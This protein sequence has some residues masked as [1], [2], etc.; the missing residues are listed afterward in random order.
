LSTT[1]AAEQLYDAL[2]TWNKRGSITITA[3]SLDF[4]KQVSPNRFL[5]SLLAL[6]G[7]QIQLYSSA[8]V[9]TY[10][11]STAQYIAITS[12]VKTYADGFVAIVQ[13]YQGSGG[14]LAEQFSRSNGS[15]L[16]AADLT[17]S[18]AASLTAFDARAS[19]V[20]ASWGASGLTVPA[21]CSS[22]GGGGGGTVAVS[23]TVTATTVFGGTCFVMNDNLAR[24]AKS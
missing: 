24:L 18:Y 11:S 1:A 9:G 17:W 10:A 2:Y 15:P 7:H 5:S 6:D 23:F 8:A 19:K 20:P 14:A 12:A 16:S 13:Q 21:T 22:G 3:T 4:F